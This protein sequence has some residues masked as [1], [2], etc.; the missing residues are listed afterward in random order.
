MTC[1]STRSGKMVLGHGCP[2]TSASC[3][4]TTAPAVAAPRASARV[5]DHDRRGSAV[6]APPARARQ[7]RRN[8][9]RIRTF[10]NL[11]SLCTLLEE[12]QKRSTIHSR[13]FR[14]RL[15]AGTPRALGNGAGR[16]SHAR[17][18]LHAPEP[19]QPYGQMQTK[20][21]F[22]VP[23][24]LASSPLQRIRAAGIVWGR[25]RSTLTKRSIH[26]KSDLSERRLR[27]ERP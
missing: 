5:R 20:I 8:S 7:G 3:G 22:R 9:E 1:E 17:S 2:S 26:G 6:R 19:A 14:R 4:L 16:R 13:V 18:D 11:A 24:Q 10:G 23:T 25:K 12:P 27:T 21:S 15:R